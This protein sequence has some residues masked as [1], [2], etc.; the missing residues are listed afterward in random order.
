MHFLRQVGYNV[1]FFFGFLLAGPYYAWRLWRRGKLWQMCGQRLGFYP[2]KIKDRI[3]KGVDVWIH[4]V[5]VGEAMM[6]VVLIKDLRIQQPGIKIVLST[7]TSTGRKVAETV[8]DERTIII[9]N[10][11]DFLWPVR[12]AFEMIR[13]QL[14]VLVEAEIW[15]NYIWCAKRREIPVYLVNARLSKRTESRYQKFA[16]FCKPVLQMVDLIFAQDEKDVP[17]LEGA[18][19]SPE[20][21]FVS[22]SL[23]YDVA[24]DSHAEIPIDAWWKNIGWDPQDTIFLAGSTHAGEE[25]MMGKIYKNLKTEFPNLKLLIAPRHAE[26]GVSVQNEVASLGLK[27]ALRSELT[28]PLF[29]GSVPE[30][31]ILNSTG[32]LKSVYA[33]ATVVFVGKSLL[34]KGGQNFIEAARAGAPIVVGPH[35]QNF[36]NLT[37]HF[38]EEG[39]LIQ[40]NSEEELESRVRS[41]LQDLES[42]ST[43]GEKGRQLYHENLGAAKRTARTIQQ[44]LQVRKGCLIGGQ[45]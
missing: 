25:F 19:F 22:G 40:V 3:G 44:S 43:L 7:T 35:M 39:G 30:V 13:P 17:R 24:E 38:R 33:K 9:Y 34:C 4:A 23:K 28:K 41:L 8:K 11:I 21:I 18:G 32:E 6:A 36:E 26:R 29:N 20:S 27:S 45:V 10:P 42:R 5:S 12:R 14:L 37:S 15:P 16:F 31:L 2:Q 1:L